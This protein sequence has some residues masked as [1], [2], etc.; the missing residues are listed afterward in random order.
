MYL[1]SS[2]GFRKVSSSSAAIASSDAAAA[3]S[4]PH[5]RLARQG[6][7]RKDEQARQSLDDFIHLFGIENMCSS[8]IS[9]S[10]G[11]QDLLSGGQCITVVR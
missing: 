5:Q 6:R 2:A 3:A 11:V 4:T 8:Y 1:V 7:T 9:I 10:S